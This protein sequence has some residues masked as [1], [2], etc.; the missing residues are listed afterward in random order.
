VC[1]TGLGSVSSRCE[2]PFVASAAGTTP[3]WAEG[4]HAAELWRLR[5]ALLT[6]AMD[7]SYR[8]DCLA[9]KLGVGR[10]LV[11][12]QA[13]ERFFGQIWSPVA[14]ALEGR[15]QAVAWMPAHCKDAQIGRR[16]LSNG[17]P[18]SATDLA[19]N[20]YVDKKAKAEAKALRPPAGQLRF[21][22]S[23]GIRLLEAATWLGQIT[24]Y[25]NHYPVPGQAA[26]G[27]ARHVRDST[28]KQKGP[29]AQPRK[30]KPSPPPAARAPGDLSSCSRW[31]ALRARIVAKSAS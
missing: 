16:M 12:A 13:A 9:V 25:A 29:V 1:Q 24:T 18:L 23:Q 19:A 7:D 26:G 8:T 20:D 3:Q 6:S 4:I 2:R 31:A 28:G 10:G 5:M 22:A 17:V 15:H 27:K 30:R 11:W 21:V 14:E